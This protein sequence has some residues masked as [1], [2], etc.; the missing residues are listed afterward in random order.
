VELCCPSIVE[1]EGCGT[2]VVELYNK[3]KGVR[4]NDPPTLMA[5]MQ[6]GYQSAF[7]MLRGVEE[8]QC[9]WKVH[10]KQYET[11]LESCRQ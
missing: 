8:P 3:S 11:L 1:T 4:I 2:V 5:G 7:K 10:V 9:A 6:F